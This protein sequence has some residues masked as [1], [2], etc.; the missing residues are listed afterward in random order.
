MFCWNSSRILKFFR[1]ILALASGLVA[2]GAAPFAHETA[3]RAAQGRPQAA[4][5]AAAQAPALTPTLMARGTSLRQAA[6]VSS[7][8]QSVDLTGVAKDRRQQLTMCI[9]HNPC[10]ALNVAF[11]DTLLT[12]S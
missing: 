7:A 5:K 4:P 12:F 2:A 3:P 1:T 10:E 11:R 6:A 8:R 9:V